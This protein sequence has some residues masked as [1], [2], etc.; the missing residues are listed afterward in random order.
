MLSKLCERF[1]HFIIHRLT[2]GS[3]K[4][5]KKTRNN[6]AHELQMLLKTMSSKVKFI[7]KGH[8]RL[9]SVRYPLTFD[10]S[11]KE[12]QQR[13]NKEIVNMHMTYRTSKHRHRN[14][15]FSL[16]YTFQMYRTSY[17]KLLP[18]DHLWYLWCVVYMY[19]KLLTV[20]SRH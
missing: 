7:Y 11:D 5:S 4:S 8:H 12:N 10:D 13:T 3:S 14:E 1:Y 2:K 19:F 16:R 20:I 18:A 9:H 17:N 6:D 15:H